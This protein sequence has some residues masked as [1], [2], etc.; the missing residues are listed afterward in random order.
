MSRPGRLEAGATNTDLLTPGE[1]TL[2]RAFMLSEK[3]NKRICAIALTLTLCLGT[4]AAQNKGALR[5]RVVDEKGGVVIGANA[6]LV[7]AN[8]VEK[9]TVTNNEGT[10]SFTALAPG[11]YTLRANA[12]GF[13]TYE[14]LA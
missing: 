2:E 11:I 7:D 14:N 5:G 10:Y 1:K 4:A 13:S 3:L 6:V 8:G 9:V 12:R